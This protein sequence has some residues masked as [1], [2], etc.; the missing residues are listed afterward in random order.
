MLRIDDLRLARREAEEAGIEVLGLVEG[1]AAPHV[2]RIGPQR[3]R[4][5]SGVEIGVGEG[6]QRL[7][8]RGDVAPE[9]VEVVGVGETSGQADDGHG[10]G[11]H[12]VAH[13]LRHTVRCGGTV[14]MR[15]RAARPGAREAPRENLGPRPAPPVSGET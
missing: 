10:M 11:G 5:V 1:R 6:R 7:D 9:A 3:R 15:G 13:G 2:V 14:E 8:P 12:G 4:Y